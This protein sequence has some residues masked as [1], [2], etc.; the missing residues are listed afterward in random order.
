MYFDLKTGHGTTCKP[1]AIGH[2]GSSGYI[3]IVRTEMRCSN[4]HWYCSFCDYVIPDFATWCCAERINQLL[5][6]GIIDE[7]E[8]GNFRL[9]LKEV[10]NG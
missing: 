2:I 7:E 1:N 8:L 3:T 6:Q 4:M 9:L 10:E 5:A